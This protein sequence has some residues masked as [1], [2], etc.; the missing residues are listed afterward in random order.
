MYLLPY[1]QLNS[2]FLLIAPFRLA[3]CR[4][5]TRLRANSA[6]VKLHQQPV[7]QAR[8]AAIAN[9]IARMSNAAMGDAIGF[10]CIETLQVDTRFA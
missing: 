7:I 9:A 1:E 5:C 10:E 8:T 3:S 4:A 6:S 2:V